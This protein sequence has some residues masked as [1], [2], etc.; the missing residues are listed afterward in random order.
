M[1]ID[2]AVAN[3]LA[4]FDAAIDACRTKDDADRL[5]SLAENLRHEAAQHMRTLPE[6]AP[7]N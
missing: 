1:T 5:V 6:V 7:S 4:A 2:D 3:L